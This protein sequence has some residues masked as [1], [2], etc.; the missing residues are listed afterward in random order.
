MLSLDYKTVPVGEVL[1]TDF[2]DRPF[3]HEQGQVVMRGYVQSLEF[4]D[5]EWTLHMHDIELLQ[6]YAGMWSDDDSLDTFHG[7]LERTSFF[8][9]R[10]KQRPASEP[11]VHLSCYGSMVHFGLILKD[12]WVDN[13]W[14]ELDTEFLTPDM[15]SG[16][17]SG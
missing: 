1:G 5:T 17:N 4:S 14:P 6:K 2:K 12:P 16:Q 11:T 10:S 13:H 9:C 7:P 3:L 8:L 15:L